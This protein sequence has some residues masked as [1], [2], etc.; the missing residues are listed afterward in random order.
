MHAL[1]IDSTLQNGKYRIL[2]ILGQG[3]FGITYL[4]I[5][6]GLERN[7]AI[8]EFFMKDFCE[9]NETTSQVTFGTESSRETVSRFREKFLKEARN[10]ARLNHPHIIRIFDVFEENGTA[11]YVMEYCE[12]GSLAD[13]V[14]NEGALSEAVATHYILQVADALDYIHRQK[15]NHLDV[16][17][18]NILLNENDEAVLI[19]FGLSK[20]YDAVTGSQTSTTP[21]GIS[22]GYAPMEQYRPGGVSEFSPQTDIYSLGATFYMLLTGI[23]PPSASDINEDG[24]PVDELK[25]KRVKRKTISVICKAMKG[26]KK[27]RLQ[28]IISFV[29]C[30]KGG[31]SSSEGANRAS[32]SK[33]A[34][35]VDD[36][37]TMVFVDTK[38]KEEEER[39][40]IEAE[41]Q[42]RK[43]KSEAEARAKAE[44]EARALAEA[45]R[46][47]IAD[48]TAKQTG[49][50]KKQRKSRKSSKSWLW[51]V[52]FLILFIIV[53]L[54]DN[55][56]KDAP[57]ASQSAS[58]TSS[59]SVSENTPKEV[60]DK[61]IVL[62]H[63]HESKRIYVYSGPVDANGIPNGKGSA[64]YPETKSCSAAT[65][66]GTFKNGI[67]SDGYLAF[68]SGMRYKGSFTEDGYYKEGTLWDKDN[69][70][71]VG[72]FKDGQPYNGIWY[73]PQGKED[74]IVENG[75]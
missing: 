59:A 62:T 39:K 30:L 60:K 14:K 43:E 44:E 45:E 70:Y 52:F 68:S 63:G 55:H 61:P 3:G 51:I 33:P 36:E 41:A 10:I 5:Q 50:S 58:S 23:T 21:V 28:D 54:N 13:R 75:K 31:A 35:K 67:L 47:A 25:A 37:A 71:Y 1:K 12:K 38:K 22:N 48:Y 49:Q 6:S 66:N 29:E 15:M 42:A 57:T 17:P 24:V 46:K 18:A 8:K 74:S 26:R 7:V 9:R 19:D 34:S 69:Y 73:T 32:T 65:F 27:E 4:A 72:T 64:K 40:R 11:Y 56:P 53:K 20:Q 16:K 2:S